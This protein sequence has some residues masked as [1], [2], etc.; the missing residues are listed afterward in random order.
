M[1]EI[2]EATIDTT[3]WKPEN[4]S[5]VAFVFDSN[6]VLQVLKTPLIEKNEGETTE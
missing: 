3:A 5:V 4:M 6:G 2:F 1:S